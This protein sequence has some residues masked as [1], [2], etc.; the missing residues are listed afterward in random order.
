M[1]AGLG[2]A[3]ERGILS[4]EGPIQ[5]SLRGADVETQPGGE[6]TARLSTS[7]ISKLVANSGPACGPGNTALVLDCNLAP[8]PSKKFSKR[9]LALS[10]WL[11]LGY[12]FGRICTNAMLVNSCAV[13]SFF[14]LLISPNLS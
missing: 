10:R 1:M 14:L 7:W 8:T 13:L 5:R 12:P 9:S 11:H 2:A 3:F 6:P 4:T